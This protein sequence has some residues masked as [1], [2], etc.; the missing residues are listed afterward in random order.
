VEAMASG[1]P[2]IAYR[3]G[4][5][6]ELIEDGVT[7]FLVATAAAA[8]A[9][10]ARIDRIDRAACRAAVARRFTLERMVDDYIALYTRLIAQ[11]RSGPFTALLP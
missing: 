6:A 11:R 1:T 10:I 3:R 2:V 9:A 7:G 4:S 5:M 8:V